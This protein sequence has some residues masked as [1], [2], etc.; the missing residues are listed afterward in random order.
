MEPVASDEHMTLVSGSAKRGK[1]RHLH[2]KKGRR[3]CVLPLYQWI[4]LGDGIIDSVDAMFRDRSVSSSA[5][6]TRAGV[7]VGICTARTNNLDRTLQASLHDVSRNARS[8]EVHCRSGSGTA[9]SA[10]GKGGRG[11]RR[12]AAPSTAQ[13]DGD[14][15]RF[16]NWKLCRESA[17]KEARAAREAVLRQNEEVRNHLVNISCP[18]AKGSVRVSIV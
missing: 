12:S 3:I 2:S 6:L 18:I 13:E 7:S 17:N 11:G 5:S 9:D 8:T 15:D 16:E 4:S 14:E 10:V 1:G